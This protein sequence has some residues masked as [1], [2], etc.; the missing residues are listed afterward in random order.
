MDRRESLELMEMGQ[1]LRGNREAGIGRTAD[2]SK[3]APGRLHGHRRGWITITLIVMGLI[4]LAAL[5]QIYGR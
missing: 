4:L 5:G 2:A 1:R 3:K